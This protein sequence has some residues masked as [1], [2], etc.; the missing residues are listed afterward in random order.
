MV[1]A[2]CNKEICF[3][4]DG[5]LKNIVITRALAHGFKAWGKEAKTQFAQLV[6]GNVAFARDLEKAE[7]DMKGRLSVSAVAQAEF[8]KR[9]AGG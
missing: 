2:L 5:A 6:Q 4:V 8:K 7:E 1:D 3:D 9:K